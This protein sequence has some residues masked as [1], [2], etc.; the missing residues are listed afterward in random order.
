[1]ILVTG[2]GGFIGSQVR[3]L[4]STRCYAVV[5]IDQR[6]A[7][8]Q[9][10]SQFSGD[11]GSTDFLARV[12]Q[13]GSFDTVIHLASVLN[14]ASRQRPV[15]ALRVNIGSSLTLLQLAARSK[16]RK[17]MFGSSIS[18]YGAKPFAEYEEVS[19]EQPAAPNTI[20]GVSRRYVELAGQNCHKRGTSQFVAL[21]ITRVVGPGAVNPSTSMMNLTTSRSHY[22][23]TLE[24]S[25]R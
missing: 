20:Y 23:D 15:E 12:M 7:I 18:V 13:T 19:E 10:Y 8:S 24:S 4:L 17:C 25:F 2:A 16:V 1:M 3:S 22:D 21:R 11:I 14:T 6:F 9:P 5:A